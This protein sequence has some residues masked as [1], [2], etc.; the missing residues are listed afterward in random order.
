MNGKYIVIV[1]NLV[2][3]SLTSC[4]LNDS[5]ISEHT[6][7]PISIRPTNEESNSTLK[8]GSGNI[9][10]SIPNQNQAVF[11]GDIHTFNVSV[12]HDVET[13]DKIKVTLDTVNESSW[14]AALCYGD[15]CTIHNGKDEVEETLQIK[16][17]EAAN[18]EIK[19]FVPKAVTLGE[20]STLEFKAMLY[21]DPTVS[22]SLTFT[23]YIQQDE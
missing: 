6:N 17:H 14:Q 5:H 20:M 4:T 21:N 13:V 3:L 16:S 7:Q 22:S 15:L 18:I 19:L 9:L 2:L 11:A 1:L 8:N 23:G 12:N 10:M